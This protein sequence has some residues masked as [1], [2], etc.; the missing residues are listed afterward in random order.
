MFDWMREK[1]VSKRLV[2]NL[3]ISAGLILVAFLAKM[4]A[5]NFLIALWVAILVLVK[6]W[7]PI[8]KTQ[9]Q[10]GEKILN[11]IQPFSLA[12]VLGIMWEALSHR[13]LY[14]LWFFVSGL[15]GWLTYSILNLLFIS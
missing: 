11:N 10:A 9:E 5:I 3:A 12:L 1:K 14:T 2:R 6:A 7:K 15:S 4:E 13:P 8:F